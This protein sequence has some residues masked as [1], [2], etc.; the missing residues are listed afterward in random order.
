[1]LGTLKLW[2]TTTGSVL[3]Q[4]PQGKNKIELFKLTVAVHTT[5][6]NQQRV[7][8]SMKINVLS[9]HATEQGSVLKQ[10]THNTV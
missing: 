7:L 9:M 3:K 4:N 10:L 6:Q 1:M 2:D 5:W 8:E